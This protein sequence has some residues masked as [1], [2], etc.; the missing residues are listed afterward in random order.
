MTP[1]TETLKANAE[2]KWRELAAQKATDHF[3][4]F[5]PPVNLKATQ[6]KFKDW[7]EPRWYACAYLRAHGLSLPKIAN[8]LHYNDHTSV[9][10]GRDKARERWTKEHFEKIALADEQE[11]QGKAWSIAA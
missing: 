1:N 6:G 4:R 2:T 8:I 5:I 10:H 3:G 9:M 7:V 11:V